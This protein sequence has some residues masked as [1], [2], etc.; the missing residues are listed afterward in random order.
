MIPDPLVPDARG[1]VFVGG[2]LDVPTIVDAYTRGCFPWRGG[3][4]IPWY[5]PN[6]RAVL[7]P[8]TFHASASLRKRRR[9]FTVAFDRDTLG[10]Q[11]RCATTPRA[12][13]TDTW[14]TPDMLAVYEELVALGYAHSVEAYLDDVPVGGLYGLVFGKIFHGESMYFIEPD[15]S[16]IALW[17][18][19]DHC[20]AR[21]FTLIDCQVQTPHMRTLGVVEWPR[22]KYLAAVTSN[23]GVASAW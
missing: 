2:T 22:A 10:A 13:E 5:C 18:L 16:K 1:R 23:A 11:R 20:A 6:P 4:D 3:V 12:Y 14:I 7:L 8:G 21:G 19:S 15:A 9:R 17:A